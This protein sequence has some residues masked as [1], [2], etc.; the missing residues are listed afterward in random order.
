[1]ERNYD[2]AGSA[3]GFNLSTAPS[4]AASRGR[5]DGAPLGG[6]LSVRAPNSAGEILIGALRPQVGGDVAYFTGAIADV[7]LYERA[8][9]PEEVRRL[10]LIGEEKVRGL[11]AGR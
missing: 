1:M 2:H 8:L 6:A 11:G 7:R 3:L 5:P 9:A 10:Y 4:A